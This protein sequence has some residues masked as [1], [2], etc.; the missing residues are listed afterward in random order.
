MPNRPGFAQKFGIAAA[1]TCVTIV[2]TGLSLGLLLISFVLD[3]RGVSGFTIGLITTIG[4]LATI[5]ASPL[6][7]SLLRRIGLMP[8]LI[9]AIALM[10]VSFGPLY[11][12]DALWLWF[13]LRFLNGVG[14]AV[15]LVTSE[16]W[17]NDLVASRRR[18]LVLGIYTAAQ[19]V[20]FAVGP[21]L[22]AVIGSDGFLP[23]TVGSGL[24]LFAAI[25]ALAGTS[26]TP[27]IRKT[28]AGS[29]LTPLAAMPMAML[30]AF[31]FGALEAGMNLL[32][33]YGLRVGKT[34][35]IAALLAMAVALGNVV[36]QIPIGFISD[37]IDRRK[38]LLACGVIALAATTLLPLATANTMLFL[39]LLVVWGGA[40]AALY[41]VGLALVGSH[42]R[43]AALA[44]ANASF[45]MHYSIG[46]VVG[47]TAAGAGID[48][49]NP[50]GFAVAMALFIAI[51]VAVGVR[52]AI[53]G[54]GTHAVRSS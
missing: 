33:I 4:G 3:A 26:S 18:G 28:A 49:W 17:I 44:G 23:F 43:G 36:F 8:T 16:F 37:K 42:Y 14:I 13:V 35:T 6:T 50:H 47:P 9:A 2:G 15:L 1:I 24:L 53:A 54:V 12:I 34:E 20:G 39:G 27:K 51:Y 21:A 40:I 52:T 5:I 31:T 10:A 22:L 19:S 48:L 29:I 11:W 30:A 46:R 25:P 41:S 45:V 7:P 38:V 32:P